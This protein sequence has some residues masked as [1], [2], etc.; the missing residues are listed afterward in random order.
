MIKSKRVFIELLLFMI[1]ALSLISFSGILSVKANV[2]TF[3]PLLPFAATVDY[4]DGELTVTV[5]GDETENYQ[6]QYWIK[7]KVTTDS[8]P[9]LNSSRYIWKMEKGFSGDKTAVIEVDN[10]YLDEEYN[11][12]VLVRVK[13]NSGI[14]DEILGTFTYENVGQ[15]VISAISFDGNNIKDDEQ[16]V[17][18]KDCEYSLNVKGNIA[19]ISY[20]VIGLGA[21]KTNDTGTFTVD[22]DSLK[23]GLNTFKVEAVYGTNKAEK[24]IRVYVLEKYDGS[25]MPVIESLEGSTI[26]GI[27]K[28]TMKVQYAD[29]TAI[30]ESDKDSFV[31]K[32]NSDGKN[33]VITRTEVV[34]DFV[35]VD[36]EVSHNG[37]G[38]YYTVG[39]VSR[40][41]TGVDDKIILYYDG[42][43]REAE[44]TL[45][46]NSESPITLTA[47]GDITDIEGD[48]LYAFYRED[49]G[50][51]V[52]IRDYSTSN[53]MVWTP[54]HAGKYIIQVRIKDSE[55]GS[56]EAT[57]SKE[58][59][60]GSTELEGGLSLKIYDCLSGDITDKIVA[61][62]AYKLFADYTGDEDML[63]MFTLY[64]KNLKTVYLNKF[65]PSPYLI[66]IPNR[67]DNYT[68][69]AR[70]II[71]DNFGYKDTAV[72]VNISASLNISIE[73]ANTE[74][75]AIINDGSFTIPQEDINV[76]Y[77][78]AP[79]NVSYTV[80][81]GAEEVDVTGSTFEFIGSG[82]YDITVTASDANGSDYQN[83]T[84]IVYDNALDMEQDYQLRQIDT[85]DDGTGVSIDII[86]YEG[87]GIP[88]PAGHGDYVLKLSNING[89]VYPEIH[90][91]LFDT[92]AAGSRIQFNYYIQ[93]ASDFSW[94]YKNPD[95]G[96]S[97]GDISGNR[98]GS[99]GQWI[100]GYNSFDFEF[101]EVWLWLFTIANDLEAVNIYIDNIEVSETPINLD[102]ENEYQW[103]YVDT[104]PDDS[105]K[106]S[107]EVVSYAD[108]GISPCVGGG[109][110]VLK[111][112]NSYSAE[113]PEVRFKLSKMYPAGTT[114]RFDYCVFNASDFS[115]NYKQPNIASKG[116]IEG[117]RNGP[118][119][120]WVHGYQ[121]CDFAF[122]EV[123]LWLAHYADDRTKVTMYIDNIE[124]VEDY[125]FTGLTFEDESD[126]K[127]IS[128]V[129]T[130]DAFNIERVS[131]AEA[132]I[133]TATNGGDYLLKLTP[134]ENYEPEVHIA[135]IEHFASGTQVSFDYY[136]TSGL[137]G[138]EWHFKQ[139]PNMS[140]AGT[141][142]TNKN[143]D[144]N[145]WITGS[146]TFNF[147]F[148]QVW[149]WCYL[150]L[151]GGYVPSDITIYID[152]IQ[153]VRP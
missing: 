125:E 8:S 23:S 58:F 26:D 94:N 63:Y 39:T 81:Y 41:A 9:N 145:S 71:A 47:S 64:S 103:G 128:T 3:D 37:Y 110:N 100:H 55:A 67:T 62:K 102:F 111:L 73:L 139:P 117:N 82:V 79:V 124:I 69:T 136:I 133:A 93:N 60:I 152:N 61:G 98:T 101:D 142:D 34:G 38:I 78:K 97:L 126:L 28:F 109:E 147:D 1:M 96:G 141:L 84:L 146:H 107:Y 112:V 89:S 44:V 20:N 10:N 11:Y 5:S 17:V 25:E 106:L 45:S 36:F 144:L 31:Y 7:T 123:W 132:G 14:V 72:S 13:D 115:W 16:L 114:F 70:A 127:L 83:I 140:D 43:V 116:D 22:F 88:K 48:K 77:G 33:A 66:F 15:P 54:T 121:T 118:V 122:D 105:T 6:Y 29:G 76:K 42:Y 134:T 19:G 108:A 85:P 119:G 153:I 151:D 65:N 86:P 2:R 104:N 137:W 74:Y 87:S 49:A 18:F 143:G 12:N 129:G 91:K 75:E 30:S 59:T 57:D 24:T 113:W 4:D 92:Y 150:G 53:Q 130:A 95:T 99:V 50:G 51:W 90:F 131:Y 32:L 56:Y 46:G 52:L 68:I 120:E 149:L 35:E 80:F 21:T 40:D 135:L 27:T 138:F 148:H